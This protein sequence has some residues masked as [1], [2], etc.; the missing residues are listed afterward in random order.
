[1]S[2][3]ASLDAL[4]AQ[5]RVRRAAALLAPSAEH[6]DSL[7]LAS[8]RARLRAVLHLHAQL[9]ARFTVRPLA[10]GEHAIEEALFVFAEQPLDARVVDEIDAVAEDLQSDQRIGRRV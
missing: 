1:M 10:L 9:A 3:G 2:S 7:G 6:D 8:G 5:E 4:R